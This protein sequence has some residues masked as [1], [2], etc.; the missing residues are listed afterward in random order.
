VRGVGE[1]RLAFYRAEGEGDKAAEAVGGEVGGRRP[2][3]A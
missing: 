3:M 2:L 1:L